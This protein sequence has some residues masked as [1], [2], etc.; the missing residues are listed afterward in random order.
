MS[1]PSDA[2]P[3]NGEPTYRRRYVRVPVS[4]EVSYV[5]EGT[6]AAKA[7]TLGD[8]GGGGVR[9]ASDEDLPLGA[10]LLLRFA[11]P[12]VSREVVARGRIVLSF[13]DAEAQQFFHGIAFTQI[14]PRDQEAIVVFVSGEVQR[15][16]MQD[17]KAAE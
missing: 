1:E 17:E 12:D 3:K 10:V 15:L 6:D 8:L 7:G 13:Y 2:V 9:L 11:M 4:L 5:R 16:A 14:D